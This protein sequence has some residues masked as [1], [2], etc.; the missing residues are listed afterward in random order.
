[1]ITTILFIAENQIEI[2]TQSCA[3]LGVKLIGQTLIDD[4][5]Q[6]EVQIFTVNTLYH[7]GKIMQTNIELNKMTAKAESLFEKL[8]NSLKP[9]A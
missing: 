3:E 4:R 2:F 8:S 6:C 7:L 5:Y 1:M 9:E